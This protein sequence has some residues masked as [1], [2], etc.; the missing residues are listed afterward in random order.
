MEAFG[1]RGLVDYLGFV[2]DTSWA[3]SL[4]WVYKSRSVVRA[5][6]LFLARGDLL[7]RGVVRAPPCVFVSVLACACMLACTSSFVF[8]SK[9]GALQERDRGSRSQ[10]EAGGLPKPTKTYWKTD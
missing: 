6:P 7:V 10:G 8:V 3:V 9:S 2:S 1:S 5:L 4:P